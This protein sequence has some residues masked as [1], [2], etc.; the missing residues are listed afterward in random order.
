MAKP[1]VSYDGPI[2]TREY[3]I[4]H[5]LKRYF[6]GAICPQGHISERHAPHGQCSQCNTERIVSY[7]QQN[8]E[9]L[10]AYGLEYKQKNKQSIRS[11][12]KIAYQKNKQKRRDDAKAYRENNKAKRKATQAASNN[13]RRM[14]KGH[15]TK[16]DVASIGSL[17]KWKCTNCLID[18]AANYHVDHIMPLSKGGTNWPSNIQLL[19]SDCNH[20]KHAKDPIDWARENGRLL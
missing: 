3:A 15:F 7:R 12:K 17:Q 18:I 10:A 16:E 8:K 13:K 4:K 5:G 2:V 11:K 14:A 9:K 1:Y 20:R 6:N 19:C